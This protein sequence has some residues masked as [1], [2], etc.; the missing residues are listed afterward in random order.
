MEGNGKL[1][2]AS[3]LNKTLTEIGINLIPSIYFDRFKFLLGRR[4]V[5]L[6]F[7]GNNN[8]WMG[9]VNGQHSGHTAGVCVWRKIQLW[10]GNITHGNVGGD[11]QKP[12]NLID[13]LASK[14]S[15]FSWIPHSH[16]SL[17][18]VPTHTNTQQP[19]LN[20]KTPSLLFAI[21]FGWIWYSEMINQAL[22]VQISDKWWTIAFIQI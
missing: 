8:S 6:L 14:C 16:L 9:Y 5:F 18:Y 17:V 20:A 11:E 22:I 2:V 4:K 12:M 1:Y 21:N 3:S 15:H 19:L 10:F 13:S 7:L